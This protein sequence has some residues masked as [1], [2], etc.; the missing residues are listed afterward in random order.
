MS[1]G[2]RVAFAVVL[3]LAA[4][5]SVL[6]AQT[7][8]PNSVRVMTVQYADGRATKSPVRDRGWVDWTPAFPRIAGAQTVDDG[9]ALNA[10]SSNTL[11]M[12]RMWSSRLR[13]CTVCRTKSACPSRA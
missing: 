13:S 1:R 4:G 10:L 2:S 8:D 6:R 11:S 9:L 5:A 3:A 12:G 7:P